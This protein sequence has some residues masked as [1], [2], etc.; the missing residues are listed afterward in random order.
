MAFLKKVFSHI[1]QKPSLYLFIFIV[2]FTSDR[3]Q[4]WACWISEAEGPF[5]YDVAE[6]Y[7]FLPATF[8]HH[9][10]S[11]DKNVPPP[12]PYNVSRRT[13]GMSVMYSPFF[14]ISNQIAK[15]YGYIQDGYSLPYKWGIH[16]GSIVYSI[17]GL[18]FCRKNLL[19]FFNEIVT[20]IALACVFFGTN[21]FL[22]VYGIGEM[23]HCYLFF[24]YSVF[25]FCS[26]KWILKNSTNHLIALG[27]IAGLI[28]L[29]RPTDVL[30]VLFIPLFKVNSINS[31]LARLQFIISK[32]IA[33]VISFLLFLLPLVIQMLIWK[34]YTGHY[35][36]D[37][38]NNERF[39][40][41]D[42]QLMN[43]L[44]S[45]RKGWLLY[46]PLMVFSLLGLIIAKFR[47]KELFTFLIVFFLSNIY[48]LSCWWDWGYGGSFGCRAIVQSYAVLIFPLAAFISWVWGFM[49]TKKVI[50]L[51]A[52]IVF[53]ISLFLLIKLNL[54]QSWQYKFGIIHW[55]G[56]N[57]KTYKYVF[58]KEALTPAEMDWLLKEVTIPDYDAMK[59]GKRN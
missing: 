54:F 49:Q 55:G 53:T 21:L 16:L 57:E 20:C 31:F 23:P 35:I 19:L 32:P 13:I 4:R 3:Y 18:W 10:F 51:S 46:T 56:M 48:L 50:N 59:Q 6:Y 44:F 1:F 9:N 17:L 52:R 12:T 29:I 11:L 30:I 25:V 36:V 43:I 47:L 58:L 41:T 38:Y 37:M 15:M 42:P 26:L 28:T 8:I 34:K 45:Y 27:F 2:I 40:F 7:Y 5:Y 33:L 24:L 22:Y 39:F 14:F